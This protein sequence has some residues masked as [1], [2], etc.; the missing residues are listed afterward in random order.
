MNISNTSSRSEYAKSLVTGQVDA[1][2]NAAGLSISEKTKSQIAGTNVGIRNAQSG[3]DMLKVADGALTGISDMLTRMRELALQASNSALYTGEDRMHFQQ[4][5]DQL[6]Q[7]ISDAA[8]NTEF[9]TKRLLDGSMADANLATNPDGSGMKIQFENTAL[10]SFGIADFDV[11]KDFD[12]KTIDQAL[13]KVETSRSKLG[14]QYNALDAVTAY[15]SNSSLNLTEANARLED[16]DV[17]RYVS[18]RNKAQLL[19]LYKMYAQKMDVHSQESFM[20]KM[21]GQ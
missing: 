19:D 17:G 13:E 5:I 21:F 4:E 15:G 14:A 1:A 11:T 20:N 8:K 10:E 16:L 9:N 18:D 7:G 6:K 12:L 2:K 3:Q